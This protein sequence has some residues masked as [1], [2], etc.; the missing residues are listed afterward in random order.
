MKKFLLTRSVSLMH[1]QSTAYL[2]GWKWKNEKKKMIWESEEKISKLFAG[3]GS[4]RVLKNCKMF[5]QTVTEVSKIFET[6][7]P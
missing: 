2:F 5:K 6:N 4:V 1:L 7:F 3:L